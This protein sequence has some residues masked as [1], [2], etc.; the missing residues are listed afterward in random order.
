MFLWATFTLHSTKYAVLDQFWAVF[1]ENITPWPAR[2]VSK[3]VVKIAYIFIYKKH[4]VD[5]NHRRNDHMQDYE[6]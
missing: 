6:L 2:N 3:L 5:V 4:F 1:F